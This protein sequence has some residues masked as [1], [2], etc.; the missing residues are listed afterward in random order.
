MNLA[1]AVLILGCIYF[2]A[3]A[4]SI[5]TKIGLVIVLLFALASWGWWHFTEDHKDLL[6]LQIEKTRSEISN[7]RA[8]TA[9]ITAQAALTARAGGIGRR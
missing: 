8:N 7:I 6:K 9:F 5:W 2:L 4:S 3:Q 1:N